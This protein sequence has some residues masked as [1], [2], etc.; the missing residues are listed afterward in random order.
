MEQENKQKIIDLLESE[1]WT[2]LVHP[3]NVE[4]ETSKLLN[5]ILDDVINKVKDL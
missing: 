3:T 5:S 1:K 4:L 2:P